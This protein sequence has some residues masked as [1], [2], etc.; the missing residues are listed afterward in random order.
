MNKKAIVIVLDSVGIGELPDAANYGD[1]GADT[2]GHII[3][4]CHP[5]LPH[6]MELGLANI[7]GASFPGRVDAPKG[8]FGKLREVSAGKDTTTGHWEIA[9]VQLAQ[10][11]PTFPNGFPQDFIERFEKAVGRGTLGNKPASGTAI[12]DE[13]GEEHIRTGKLIVY[14]SADSVLQICG[15]EETMGLE[16]LYH[17][18]EIA[19]ELTMKDEW[20]VGRVIAR[21]YVGKKK[22]EFVRTANRH[23][24]A[25]KPTGKT[26]LNAMQEAGYD[27]ISIGKI[28]DI[29]C[30]EGITESLKSK[31]SVHGME[32]TIETAGK[33]FTGLCF[34]NLVDFDALWGH[35][36]NPEGY[37][38]EIEKFDVNLGKLLEQLKDD[39]LL[40]ITA[41]HGN[42]PTY[43]G[44]DHTREQVPLL[45]YSPSM[46][47][48]GL[49]ETKDT[50]A[51]IGA[52][53]AENF[54]VEMPEGTIGTSILPE[55]K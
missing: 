35:R 30:G 48:S 3:N 44:T 20:K 49:Q 38:K 40:V 15:N 37:G 5:K 33:D 13:L 18:C 16:T 11:F 52:S 17:Y 19:R 54:G 45:A 46:K 53:V 12:L 14:T 34:V 47:E 23:D 8:C 22:G 27:V 50:F 55:W 31:S 25:V 1:K 32:Q 10:A 2:L 24:Y 43:T 36:R 21:P 7:D 41:D 42:D 28:N 9:G 39:D 4:T 51:V 26:V 29:F 6:L